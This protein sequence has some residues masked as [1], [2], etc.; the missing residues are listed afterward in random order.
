MNVIL[1]P[2]LFQ[3]SAFL[4]PLRQALERANHAVHSPGFETTTLIGGEL[5]LLLEKLD[6][7]GPAA[8]VG[9]S[10]GGLLAT[11]AGQ[12]RHPNIAVIIGLGSPITGEVKTYAPYYEARSILG[13]LIPLSGAIEIR[14]FCAMHLTLPQDLA[15]QRWILEI[16]DGYRDA[17]GRKTVNAGQ[18]AALRDIALRC[19]TAASDASLSKDELRF[20]LLELAQTAHAAATRGEKDA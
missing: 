1:I 5:R 20:N 16:L 3:S 8:L 14:R 11:F 15:V 13:W 12:T 7:V 6:E 19:E 9:H 4:Q 18:L 17:K 2:G 10:A